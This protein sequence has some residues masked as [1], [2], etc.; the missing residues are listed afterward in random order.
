MNRSLPS[1]SLILFIYLIFASPAAADVAPDPLTAGN[2]LK[3]FKDEPTDVRMVWEDVRVKVSRDEISTVADFHMQNEGGTVTME[4]GFPYVYE[5]NFIEFH[6]W[7]DGREVEVREGEHRN[8]GH[9][10]ATVRWKLWE[11]TFEKGDSCD[12]RVEYR[13][14]TYEHEIAFDWAD[15]YRTIPPDEIDEA[16]RLT[17]KG[18]VRYYLDSGKGWKGVLDHCRVEIE[19]EN[20]TDANIFKFWPETGEYTGKGAVWEFTDY[21]PSMYVVLTYYPGMEVEKIPPYLIGLLE[22]YP[23]E[24]HLSRSVGSM[25]RG[26]LHRKDLSAQVYHSHL[27]V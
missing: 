9:K 6:A 20:M 7:V 27:V 17:R 5:G 3:T 24:P 26:Q 1:S 10:K 8:V 23:R 4:V 21:E 22:R 16:N 12:V 18:T 19:L 13:T 25:L 15:K 14:E 2:N 11:I